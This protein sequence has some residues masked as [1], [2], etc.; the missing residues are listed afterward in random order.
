MRE[1]QGKQLCMPTVTH[2]KDQ[3]KTNLV[4]TPYTPLLTRL[5]CSTQQVTEKT[6]TE[7]NCLYVST[8]CF[9]SSSSFM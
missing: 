3:R 8:V 1:K 2:C 5:K 6:P 4:K 7:T 9:P